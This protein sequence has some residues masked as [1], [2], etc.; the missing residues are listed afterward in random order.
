MNPG[1]ISDNNPNIERVSQTRPTER[2]SKSRA[3]AVSQKANNPKLP[4]SLGTSK[5]TLEG[6]SKARTNLRNILL[7]VGL[8][9][10]VGVA[11]F[12]LTT[13]VGWAALGAAIAAIAIKGLA[14][15]TVL[16]TGLAG[17]AIA[18]GSSLLTSAAAALTSK[19]AIYAYIG[20]SVLL[21]GLVLKNQTEDTQKQIKKNDKL[22]EDDRELI[23]K[24]ER[25]RTIK[26]EELR[27]ERAYSDND[28]EPV[29]LEDVQLWVPEN[30]DAL[31][32][33]LVELPPADDTIDAIL[34]TKSGTATNK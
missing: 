33:E 12:L 31:N 29:S 23:A 34:Q 2:T 22:R 7:L 28:A 18:G 15:G 19:I 17:A 3:E 9:V 26:K 27:A 32:L 24:E 10:A 14:A 1:S 5:S 6:P 30:D 8:T 11:L 21:V 25:D 20:L 4:D 16:A 13:P